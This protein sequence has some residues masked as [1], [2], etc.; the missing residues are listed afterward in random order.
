MEEEREGCR[1]E[2]RVRMEE[3]REEGDALTS[4]GM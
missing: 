3:E 4:K 1:K 2:E